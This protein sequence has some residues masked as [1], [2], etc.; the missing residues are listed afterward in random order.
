MGLGLEFQPP[1]EQMQSMV[2]PMQLTEF[3]HEGENIYEFEDVSQSLAKYVVMQ[4]HSVE[5]SA[6]ESAESCKLGTKLKEDEEIELD[7]GGGSDTSATGAR[8]AAHASPR[9]LAPL[10]ASQLQRQRDLQ[11]ISER[12]MLSGR[13]GQLA[14]QV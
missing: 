7:K 12:D 3:E 10:N 9:H 1:A 13:L 6:L 2:E 11:I 14:G 5:R 8:D 4:H